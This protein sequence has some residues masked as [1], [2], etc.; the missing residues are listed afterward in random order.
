MSAPAD[1]PDR[2]SRLNWRMISL[3]IAAAVSALLIGANAHLIYVAVVSQPDCVPHA[4]EA[5]EN[6][7]FR[8]AEPSC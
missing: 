5:G 8:A 4:K 2:S 7:A 3:S 6:G 1:A